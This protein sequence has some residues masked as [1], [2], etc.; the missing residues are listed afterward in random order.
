MANRDA[1]FGARITGNLYSSSY[2]GKS[3]SYVIPA[4]YG[5]AVFLGDFV[6][7]T[8]TA[9]LG[10]DNVYHPVVAQTVAGA[11]N[12]MTGIVVGFMP[13]SDNV[14]RIYRP[15]ST[16]RTVYV[17]DDPYTIFEIQAKGTLTAAD[18]GQNANIVVGAGSTDFGTSGMEVDLATLTTAATGQIR[19]LDI[20]SSP[21]NEFGANAKVI[22][23][24]NRHTTRST[25]GI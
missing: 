22:A 2:N 20:C 10:Q 15:A 25:T 24:I 21:D 11:N 7:V 17:A 19:I 1:V 8:G 3:R 23:M 14:N 5:T 12:V 9:E 6:T 16:L 4:S 18:I 13:D